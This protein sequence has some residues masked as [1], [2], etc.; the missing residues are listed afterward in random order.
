LNFLIVLSCCSHPGDRLHT[1]K[2]EADSHYLADRLEKKDTAGF[3]SGA[4]HMNISVVRADSNS[5]IVDKVADAV[6]LQIRNSH[7]ELLGQAENGHSELFLLRVADR[8]AIRLTNLCKC[9]R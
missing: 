8:E 4:D 5:D 1:E 3:L 7:V 9:F 2:V 6:D